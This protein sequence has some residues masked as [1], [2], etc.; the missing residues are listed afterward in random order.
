[1]KL[2][3]VIGISLALT[4][5][6]FGQEKC[7]NKNKLCIPK[8]VETWKGAVDFCNKNGWKLAVV[9]SEAKQKKIESIGKKLDEF[10]RGK[11]ELWI[12]ANDLAKKGRFVWEA[13]KK[14]L[15]YTNWMSGM[16]DNRGGK[17]HCVHMWY[18]KAKNYNW[19]WNDVVCESK[20][21]F[22]CQSKKQ[23]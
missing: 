17:E 19:G 15:E 3:L 5:L 16:P 1:M 13:N 22:V 20:R 10:K 12:G 8:S 6:V 2:S 7:D 21:R 14:P 9:N 4:G 11:V 18:E 23:N